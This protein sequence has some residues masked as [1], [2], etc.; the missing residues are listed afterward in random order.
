MTIPHHPLLMPEILVIIANTCFP[1]WHT[2]ISLLG[3]ELTITTPESHNDLLACLLVC[4]A[5]N[6]IFS[7]VLYH[8]YARQQTIDVVSHATL[9]RHAH[10]VRAFVCDHTEMRSDDSI[11]PYHDIQFPNLDQLVLLD[12]REIT[13]PL[14]EVVMTHVPNPTR[15]QRF[16]WR[17]MAFKKLEIPEPAIQTLLTFDHLK[18]LGLFGWTLLDDRF[19]QILA[20]IR[21]TLTTLTVSRLHGFDELP[22]DLVL[23][24]L[25]VLN[26]HF[27]WAQSEA[28]VQLPRV[29]PALEEVHLIVDT[30]FDGDVLAKSLAHNCPALKT[31][32][33][34]EE[35]SMEFER[36]C[37]IDNHEYAALVASPQHLE[38]V[39]LGLPGLTEV[40]A[41]ALASQADSLVH[42]NLRMCQ[43]QALDAKQMLKILTACRQLKHVELQDV[44]GTAKS[45][46]EPL[47][48]EP[49]ACTGLKTLVIN[50]YNQVESF[51]QPE[52]S[53]RRGRGTVKDREEEIS[54]LFYL[55][56]GWYLDP[57]DCWMS[58]TEY[59]S[60]VKRRLMVHLAPF[61]LE[62]LQLAEVEFHRKE[63]IKLVDRDWE[64][65]VDES[66]DED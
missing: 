55:D 5:W 40:M 49:W 41:N 13:R 25:K 24:K 29:C 60:E 50:G 2:D 54:Q 9:T 10:L 58:G 56:Q 48:A 26:L 18:E 11:L 37:F 45:V 65:E 64:Q 38:F 15:L 31:L 22:R 47:V 7:P 57:N 62:R 30:L 21:N 23:R 16:Q 8:T 44:N 17:R 14:E 34:C 59:D 52:P 61:Q 46:I 28:L 12:R 42:L 1:E 36:G 43:G 20:N 53:T 63:I 35:Y 6:A 27:A 32:T 19:P 66:T 3:D 39:R 33:Y 51:P 4:K